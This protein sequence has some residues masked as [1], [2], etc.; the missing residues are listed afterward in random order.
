VAG[1][2]PQAA[3]RL[4]LWRAILFGLAGLPLAA[5]STAFLIYLP[6][7]LTSQLGVPLAVVGGSW[8]LV[9]VIDIVVDPVL[10]LLM[11]GTRTPLGRYRPWMAF[12]APIFMLGLWMLF[13]A[14]VGI[15]QA[16]L[17]GWLLVLYVALSILSLAHPAWAA[18]LARSYDERSRLYGVMAAVAIA[19]V[20]AVLAIPVVGGLVG[21]DG[22]AVHAMGWFLV[23]ATPISIGITVLAT[24]ETINPNHRHEPMRLADFP[25]I[26]KKRDLLRLYAAQFSMMLGPGWMSAVVIFFCKDYMHFTTGQA[27]ELLV[28][29][30]AAGLAGAPATAKLAQRI[31]KH[32]TIMVVAAVYSAGLLTVLLPPKGVVLAFVPIMLWCGFAGAGFDMT[33]RSMLADVSDEVRLEEG[34]ARTSLIYALYSLAGKL[35]N[36]LAIGL[37]F[38]L[39]QRL[40]YQPKLGLANSPEAIRSLGL[41]FV[42]GPIAFVILG[43]ACMIGWRLT[44]DRHAEIRTAL[45]A[46][47]AAAALGVEGE[48]IADAAAAQAAGG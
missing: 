22:G 7:H 29:Y 26:L 10:G 35:A 16:Y 48:R 36:A 9:R 37:T 42:S 47:D 41:T 14:P 34:K 46:R 27:S 44:A 13:F 15:T 23:I 30:I 2:A 25:S 17:V 5:A 4:S 28:V 21:A 38:P 19:S 45:E 12:A 31:G 1:G 33:I 8:A 20:I 6:P 43:A 32:R 40:G 39:L 18:A 24:P 11:D 3:E